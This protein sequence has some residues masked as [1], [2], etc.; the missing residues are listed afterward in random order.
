[1]AYQIATAHSRILSGRALRFLRLP[2]CLLLCLLLV[3]PGLLP[4]GECLR[5]D[6][7]KV[8]A[9]FVPLEDP[10]SDTVGIVERQTYLNFQEVFEA[11]LAGL[12]GIVGS[13]L[14]RLEDEAGR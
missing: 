5:S 11:N 6:W 2:E 12:G 14:L 7:C 13:L 10:K 9:K 8:G 1:M 4:F 3:H